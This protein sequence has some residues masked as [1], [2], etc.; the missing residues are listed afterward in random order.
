MTNGDNKIV[1]VN[2]GRAGCVRAV[3]EGAD[4]CCHPCRVADYN[5]LAGP[6]HGDHADLC[7]SRHRDGQACHL[8]GET[9]PCAGVGC[10]AVVSLDHKYCCHPCRSYTRSIRLHRLTP[11]P[12]VPH[13]SKCGSF[14]RER[15]VHS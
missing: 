4:F 1:A 6:R 11:P 14:P 2:C 13:S 7:D 5:R 9:Q 3:E 8:A 15:K 10:R 12:V